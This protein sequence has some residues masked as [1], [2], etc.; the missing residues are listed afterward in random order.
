MGAPQTVPLSCAFHVVDS[1]ILTMHVE[2]ILFDNKKNA[3]DYSHN[4][5]KYHDA[6]D[7]P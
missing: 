1:A 5:K 3:A 4:C 2:L 7:R 6:A